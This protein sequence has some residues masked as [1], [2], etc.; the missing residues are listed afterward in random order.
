MQNIQNTT[1]QMIS[2]V[3]QIVW[4]A[5]NFGNICMAPQIL[6][7]ELNLIRNSLIRI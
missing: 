5:L 3:Y 6:S 1:K 2:S 7:E 4:F